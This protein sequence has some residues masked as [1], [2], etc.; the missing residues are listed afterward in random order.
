M[1]PLIHDQQ[2][3]PLELFQVWLNLPAADKMVDPHFTMLWRDSI[4]TVTHTDDQGL[5]TS[6]RVITGNY[7][8]RRGPQTPPNSW[9]AKHAAHVN[10][11]TID[12]DLGATWTLPATVR[13][14]NRTVYFYQGGELEVADV[15]VPVEHMIALKADAETRFRAVNQAARLLLLEGRP[16]NE[17]VAHYGPFVMN[18]RAELE[19]AFSD[20]QRTGFGGWPWQDAAPV[21][22]REAG[23]F[24]VHADGK[25][26]NRG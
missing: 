22:E 13:E 20:Y 10:I 26:E 18:T 23:R 19:Q 9:A 14:A 1:F 5:N 12:I 16:I 3:N 25:K 4:Q 11:W 7:L 17:P 2:T 21:H 6:V 8:E 15:I 24:A